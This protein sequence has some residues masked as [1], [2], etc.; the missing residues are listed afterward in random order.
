MST[1][2]Y[3]LKAPWDGIAIWPDS[4]VRESSVIEFKTTDG[5]YC[6]TL[7][8]KNDI[9]PAVIRTLFDGDPVYQTYCGPIVHVGSRQVLKHLKNEIQSSRQLLSERGNITVYSKLKSRCGYVELPGQPL[10]PV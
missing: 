5:R 9:V 4:L 1:Y 7:S 6:G 8:I 10:K 3:E 2:Y